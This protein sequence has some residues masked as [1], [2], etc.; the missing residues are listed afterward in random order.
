MVISVQ[1]VRLQEANIVVLNEVIKIFM[2]FAA[3][4]SSTSESDM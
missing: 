3:V 4:F 1:K 2:N